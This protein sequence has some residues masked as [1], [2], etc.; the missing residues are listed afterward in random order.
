MCFLD[1]NQKLTGIFVLKGFASQG[2]GFESNTISLVNLIFFGNHHLWDGKVYHL[3]LDATKI[4]NHHL[5]LSVFPIRP[6]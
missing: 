3:N 5:V 4:G 1:S 2:N 6:K